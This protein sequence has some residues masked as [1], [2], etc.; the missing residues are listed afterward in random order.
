MALASELSTAGSLPRDWRRW[1]GFFGAFVLGLVLLVAAWAKALDPEAFAEQVRGEGLEILLSARILALAGIGVEVALGFALVLG[2]RR[3]WVLLPAVALVGFFLFLTG[4]AYARSLR[5]EALPASSCGCFGNL[6]RRTPAE[7]FWQDLLLLVPPLALAFLG[8][9]RGGRPP[10][11]RLAAVVVASGAALAFAWK[12]P[13][14]PLDDLAT[15]LKPGVR[16][17]D[18]CAGQ[19]AEAVCLG[20]LAPDLGQ[21]RQLVVLA[22]L[23]APDFIAAIPALNRYADSGPAVPLS[24]VTATDPKEFM[25]FK[26][27]FGPTFAVR[28][29]P[30]ELLRPLYRRLPRSFILEDGRVV[31]TY[32][33]LPENLGAAAPPG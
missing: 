4:R 18:L 29:A 13:A 5:G 9:E 20:T 16:I 6:V 14:L 25:G 31:S 7:A 21:G 15:R 30:A 1:L 32:R 11:G 33:G 23:D 27:K 26:F 10:K 28:S 24:V 8:R 2:I 19:G 17:A 3:L 12:A 22:D